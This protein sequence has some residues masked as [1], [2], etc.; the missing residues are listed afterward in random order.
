MLFSPRD[1]HSRFVCGSF[2]ENCKVLKTFAWK[3]R[4]EFGSVYTYKQT[5][6]LMNFRKKVSF[7]PGVR[8][9]SFVLCYAFLASFKAE[10]DSLARDTK[11]KE[12]H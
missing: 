6:W 5:L 12:S 8:I 11:R 3:M 9:N 7:D 1:I 2:S 10:V 4:T